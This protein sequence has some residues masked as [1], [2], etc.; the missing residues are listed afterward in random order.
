MGIVA[1]AQNAP[2]ESAEVGR[3]LA[4][5]RLGR[6]GQ[7][8]RER[9]LLAALRL[10][11]DLQGPPLTLTGVA[12]EASMRL[13][14]LYL[15]FPD[16]IELLLAV[17]RRVTDDANAAFMDKLRVRWP[18]DRLGEACLELIR[19]HH[20]FWK[21]YARLLQ[22]RNT[23]SDTEA[24]IMDYRQEVTRPIIQFLMVQMDGNNDA[25]FTCANL[26]IVILTSFERIAA[27]VTNPNFG[28]MVRD[29]ICT[30]EEAMIEQL[31][32]AEARM[33]ELAIRDRRAAIPQ[34]VPYQ[35]PGGGE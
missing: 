22:L 24:R 13:T 11:D 17:L 2:I 3:N 28:A 35:A 1:R 10:L 20:R 12:R 29:H 33:L 31:I 26:A 9:I 8:T 23:L 4:G 18:D 14:N 19:A 32:A 30:S 21:R 16:M 15:Y 34:G 27:I 5:Q 7:E 6:K 25:H